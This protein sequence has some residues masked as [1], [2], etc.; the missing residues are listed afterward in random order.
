MANENEDDVDWGYLPENLWMMVG[1]YVGAISVGVDE[2]SSWR[3]TNMTYLAFDIWNRACNEYDVESFEGMLPKSITGVSLNGVFKANALG[4][5]LK[6]LT[7]TQPYLVKLDFLVA[8]PCDSSVCRMLG[9]LIRCSST[10]KT[11]SLSNQSGILTSHVSCF[12]WSGLEENQS[13]ETL[14]IPNCKL[15]ADFTPSLG[16]IIRKHPSLKSLDLRG[17]EF[18][19]IGVEVICDAAIASSLQSLN[20]GENMHSYEA[21]L[22]IGK[23]VGANTQ[24]KELELRENKLTAVGTQFLKRAL[25]TNNTIQRLGLSY[26]LLENTGAYDIADILVSNESLKEV[27]LSFN[28]IKQDGLHAICAALKVN[29]TLQSLDLS[30]NLFGDVGAGDIADMF[31]VNTTLQKLDVRYTKLTWESGNLLRETGNCRCIL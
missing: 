10:L 24:L 30:R 28:F 20:L 17:N 3:A 19:A 7:R 26:N 22:T 25:E 2:L 18:G 4:S 14:N 11:V 16:K 23:L 13:I 27:Q 21:A 5:L 15:G 12:I 29:A 8:M 6:E 1:E 9:Q 31:L